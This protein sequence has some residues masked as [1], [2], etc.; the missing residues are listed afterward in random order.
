[1]KELVAGVPV[2]VLGGVTLREAAAPLNAAN[3]GVL[4]DHCR[5]AAGRIATDRGIVLSPAPIH[6]MPASTA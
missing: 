2:A 6:W 5:R 1:M 4:S 3:V